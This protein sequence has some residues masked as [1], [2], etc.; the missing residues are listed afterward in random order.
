MIQLFLRFCFLGSA[1]G[2][3]TFVVARDWLHSENPPHMSDIA[4]SFILGAPIWGTLGAF[5]SVPLGMVPAVV[6]CLTYWRVLYRLTKVN[7]RPL[8]RAGLGA[9][10]GGASS[11][12]YGGLLFSG[13]TGPGSYGVA[14]NVWSWLIA[15]VVGGTVSALTAGN[16]TYESCFPGR[17]VA[18]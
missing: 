13:G 11:V 10:T 16:G 2:G 12:L 4:V 9:V 5:I 8:V 18:S 1:I 14:V 7:P 17:S 15:G 3:G 6:A